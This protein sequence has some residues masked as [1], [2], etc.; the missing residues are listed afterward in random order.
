MDVSYTI[1]ILSTMSL[2]EGYGGISSN[3]VTKF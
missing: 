1:E 2:F 3:V